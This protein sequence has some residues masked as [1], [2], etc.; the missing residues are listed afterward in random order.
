MD[1]PTLPRLIIAKSRL[2]AATWCSRIERAR[3]A[4]DLMNAIAKQ[5]AGGMSLNQAISELFPS[6]RRGWAIRHWTA[7]QRHGF[8]GLIE[9]RL[10]R[11]PKQMRRCEEMVQVARLANPKVTAYDYFLSAAEIIASSL[12]IELVP[13]P[14]ENAADIERVIESFA[15]MPN[16]GLV[17]PPDTTTIAHRDLII[18]LAARHRIPAVYSLRVFVT[19]GGLISYNTDRAGM[20]RQAA[21]Y[22]ARILHGA[23]PSDL[24]VQAPTKFETI[25]NLKTA[26]ALAL[27]VPPGLLVAADEVIE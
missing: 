4:E 11:E 22:V 25:L 6:S 8:E 10:P 18:A 21:S 15:R 27:T 23:N 5:R 14:V 12:A 16:S 2:S 17:L 9:A 20:Y 19:A 26:K 7:Y 1:T 3:A 13:S 24:P